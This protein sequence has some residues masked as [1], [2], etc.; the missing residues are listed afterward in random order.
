MYATLKNIKINP[1]K[2]PQVASPP[3]GHN[4]GPV[5]EENE[6]L[7]LRHTRW[8]KPYD[9]IS[10]IS[11]YN[12]NYLNG[13]YA[14]AG[15]IYHH[16]GHAMAEH[17]HRI[18]PTRKILNDPDVIWIL[19]TT[20]DN[21]NDC[22]SKFPIFIQNI[23][24]YLGLTDSNT[25]ILTKPT[26][27][28]LLH[29]NSQESDLG[30]GPEPEYL[31]LL[32]DYAE[33][34]IAAKNQNF[35]SKIYVS[36][37]S[38]L[39]GGFLGESYVDKLFLENG[40]TIFKPENFSLEEQ[41]SVYMHADITIF[42]EGS[43]C[44]GVELLG[45]LK[46]VCILLNRRQHLNDFQNILSKRYSKYYPFLQNIELG[47]TVL[48]SDGTS[49]SNLGVS[50][51][52][53]PKIKKLLD[54]MALP[55]LGLDLE[56]Y[57]NAAKIDLEKYIEYSKV[58]S[59][60]P[61]LV[62]HVNFIM[63]KFSNAAEDVLK[64]NESIFSV[65]RNENIS[66]LEKSQLKEKLLVK[67]VNRIKPIEIIQKIR[68]TN[69]EVIGK[70][71]DPRAAAILRAAFADIAKSVLATVEG[72]VQIPGL[73]RFVIKQIQREVDGESNTIKRVVF[74]PSPEPKPVAVAVPFDAA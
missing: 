48:L 25:I 10:Y 71:P 67:C 12:N 18:I 30:G 65:D 26:I 16:F 23:Y 24:N 33:K 5:L 37:S 7:P 14:Y 47:S 8:R 54:D 39:A 28:E 1:F 74:L 50:L 11:D 20:Y 70:V 22:L 46:G 15:P 68:Q 58:K 60:S 66:I 42:A 41:M 21:P 19:V 63:D 34:N 49:L 13:S 3:I 2:H 38:F 52:N 59:Q 72:E 35:A 36:R 69:P 9:S 43:A 53:L 62:E 40:F 64:A 31:Q 32:S 29:I 61:V 55:F 57:I 45:A 4:G 44:H 56:L 73:G 51:F 27:V 6:Y 17:V